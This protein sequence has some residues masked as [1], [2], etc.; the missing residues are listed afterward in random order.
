MIENWIVSKLDTLETLGG[1]VWPVATP[2][3]SA[4]AP[5]CIFAPQGSVPTVDLGGNVIFR[6]D[7]VKVTLFDDDYDRL[8]SLA[9]AAETALAV[10]QAPAEGGYIFSS[11]VQQTD[12]DSFDLTVELLCRTV[13]V[14]V[15]YWRETDG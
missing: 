8:T 14:T 10:Q 15:R 12:P 4:P 7:T 9:A 2:V 1:Q 13:L 6:T 3:G 11:T 5:F